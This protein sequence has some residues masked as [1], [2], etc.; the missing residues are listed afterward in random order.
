MKTDMEKKALASL[1]AAPDK[2]W[3]TIV[4]SDIYDFSLGDEPY[5]LP[6][7]ARKMLK[8]RKFVFRWIEDD[9]ARLRE[10]MRQDVPNK[11]WPC[12]S[13]NTPFLKKHVDKSTG[14]I[15]CKDQILV[16]KPYWMAEK[17][18]EAITRS[19]EGRLEGSALT[20]KHGM[21]ESDGSQ[22]TT[23]EESRIGKTDVVMG[24][25]SEI[26]E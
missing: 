7:E 14:G 3:E 18:T 2:E 6:T 11:W 22:W 23:G 12:N 4:E 16:F 25:E 9:M 10:V 5:P 1:I 20:A 13:T 19:E 26:T 17:R 24:V 21:R 8:E 15:H